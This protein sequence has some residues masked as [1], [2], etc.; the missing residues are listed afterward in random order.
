MSADCVSNIPATCFPPP[1]R[2]S[3]RSLWMRALPTR[4]ISPEPSNALPE[5]PLPSFRKYLDVRIR[6]KKCFPETR[7]S[8]TD[9]DILFRREAVLVA[10]M[11]HKVSV[12]QP[13]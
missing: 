9:Y 6:D 2:L 11:K 3:F 5:C 12:F 10:N 13:Q 8:R 1:I 4:A 7:R